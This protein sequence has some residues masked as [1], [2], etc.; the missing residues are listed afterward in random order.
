M[1][2]TNLPCDAGVGDI[3]RSIAYGYHNQKSPWKSWFKRTSKLLVKVPKPNTV[4]C[5]RWKKKSPE[6][7]QMTD[8]LFLHF[9]ILKISLSRIS[10]F[11]FFKSC[12]VPATFHCNWQVNV[13]ILT[14]ATR[15][16]NLV[17]LVQFS[18]LVMSCPTICDPMDW[19]TPAFLA[20]SLQLWPTLQSHRW[21]PTR[22]PRPWDPLGK[23]TGVGCHFLLQCRKV[24]HESEVAQSCPTPID[25]TDCNLPGSYVHGICQTRVLEWAAIDFSITNSRSL[26][27][28]MSI[29]LVMPSNH[30]ILCHPLL[31]SP[32][33]FPSIRVLSFP[34]A[35]GGQNIGVSASAPVLPMNIQDWFPLGLTGWISLQSKRLS[36]VFS[37]TTVQKHQFFSAQFSL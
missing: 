1:K 24:R 28:L 37:N 5:N 11:F 29:K 22:L 31:L 23:N 35:S 14:R 18:H 30:L 16:F 21:Q 8:L 9:M 6:S 17:S 25:P 34:F 20:K 2:Q 32:S 19:S 33:I 15:K 4:A 3:L 7:S 12:T 13:F 26:L 10:F 27:K 36:R